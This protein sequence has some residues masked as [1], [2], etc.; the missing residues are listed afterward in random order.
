MPLS[1]EVTLPKDYEAIFP[2]M[3][4]V[5]QQKPD[6]IT[7]I[8]QNA[9]NPLLAFFLPILMLFGWSRV[10]VPICRKCKPK[11]RLQRWGRELICWAII[12]GAV[13]F[14]MPHFKDWSPMA[15]KITVGVLALVV[16]V[17]W[18]LAEAWWPRVFNTT[19]SHDK[20]DYEFG[21]PE[22][23]VEFHL[24]NQDKVIKSD[25]AEIVAALAN[26]WSDE[27]SALMEKALGKEHNMVMHAIIP[28]ALGGALDLYYYPNGIPGTGIATKELSENPGEGSSNRVFKSY[29]LVM[30]TRQKLVLDDAKDEETPF[31]KAHRNISS[32]LNPIARYSAQA[33]LNPNETCEFP[34]D[35]ERIGGKCLIFDVYAPQHDF[36]TEDFGLMLIMEVHRSEMDFARS[37]GGS[38][39][40]R[41]LKEAG[42]YPYSVMD[43]DP[44][45]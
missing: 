24:K 45:A 38:E 6:S 26:D 43:R 16:L 14:I 42:H 37:H 29:E 30:F 8:S 21:T 13:W 34:A 15:R 22:Y 32:I 3:C 7:K 39:L 9:Q 40:I 2:D 12:I 44:V 5:C 31:G 4:I 36:W 20:I 25:V 11:F 27:K 1:A 19:A 18:C 23:A 41:L 33:K 17:P 10:K 35:M 28:F